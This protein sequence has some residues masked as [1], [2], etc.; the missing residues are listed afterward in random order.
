MS[1]RGARIVVVLLTL[2]LQ[3]GAVYKLVETDRRMA[4][5]R[6]AMARLGNQ[7]ERVARLLAELRALQFAHVAG[8]Q[9][10]TAA[11]AGDLF[12]DVERR[13]TASRPGA[14]PAAAQALGVAL[15][16]LRQLREVDGRIRTFVAAGD[17]AMALDLA[18]GE[19]REI[20][21]NLAGQVGQANESETR[22]AEARLGG[23]RLIEA[24]FLVGALGVGLLALLLLWPAYIGSTTPLAKELPA[25]ADSDRPA[26]G[27][28]L[29]AV[30]VPEGAAVAVTPPPP[31]NWERLTSRV[32]LDL[33][34]RLCTD[35]VRLADPGSLPDL[36]ARAAG[37]L[38][39]SGLI[40]WVVDAAGRSLR[41]ASAH[42]YPA[43]ALSRIG[44]IPVGADNATAAA[45]RTSALQVVAA[46][47]LLPGAFAVPMAGPSGCVGV[48]AAEVRSGREAEPALHAV[49]AII[50]AQVAALVQPAAPA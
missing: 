20:T 31:E 1:K 3:A 23:L 26:G 33:T 19:A 41:P 45:F 13:I 39:A 49:A 22:A 40:V 16:H 32:D 10:A 4:E 8:A 37:L 43:E 12:D 38:D 29:R 7:T 28:G 47:G 11:P 21:S 18:L 9:V 17:H 15:D 25:P 14:G 46:D 24:Y 5:A 50:A 44:A 30:P 2:V 35:L 27:L 6:A 34:A 42:G 48:L 36:L